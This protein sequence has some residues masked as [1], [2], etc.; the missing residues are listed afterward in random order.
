MQELEEAIGCFSEDG[1]KLEGDTCRVWLAAAYHASKNGG[2]IGQTI[3]PIAD[4]RGQ[5]IHPTLIAIHQAHEWLSGLQ[6]NHEVGRMVGDLLTRAGR[7]AAK[8]PAT[9]R[10]LHRM[11]H[12]VQMPNPHMIIQSFGHALVGVGGKTLSL[13]D[14]QTQSVRDLF[15]FF[16]TT[17]RPLT[18]EQISEIL[19]PEMDEPHKLKLRFKN[20]I[21]RLRRAVG[22]EIVAY[23]DALY[24][25]NR[26]LDFEYDVEAFEAFLSRARSTTDPMKQIEYY[27]TAVDLVHGPFLEDIYADWVM[28][29]RERLS[30]VY[31]ST[32][33]TLGELLYKQAQ[34][35]RALAVCQRVLDYEITFEAAYTLLMQIYH[36]MGDRPA[37]MRTYQT[38]EE[39]MRRELG[40]PPSKETQD[41]YKRLIL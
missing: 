12:V 16:L 7:L 3:K 5:V 35:E 32:L 41:L 14:W 24:K 28:L 29:E 21:Y 4:G 2:M 1:R 10:Q 25:F 6:S 13:S 40:L 20:E 8:L 11:A 18:K 26:S 31:L 38:C 37:I 9:R 17:P 30:Q 34:W 23:E 27:Q 33:I 36:R 19:W 22:Q 39:V 15:F